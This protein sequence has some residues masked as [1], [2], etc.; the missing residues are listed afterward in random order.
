MLENATVRV[1]NCAC[2]QPF[3]V[4]YAISITEKN[5]NHYIQ[6][7]KERLNNYVQTYCSNCKTNAIAKMASK[8]ANPNN[9]NNDGKVP[10][11]L[12]KYP[13]IP[14]NDPQSSDSPHILCKNCTFQIRANI[15]NDT[16][17]G[18]MDSNSKIVTMK[19][20]V[21]M[22]KHQVEIKLLKPILK[23]EDGGCCE[24]L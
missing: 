11:S 6:Q 10:F 23:S 12:N 2:G 3:D 21:C 9:V 1:P 17:Q 20:E 7:A 8:K 15:I 22:K 13:I 5:L 19:C 16:K 14:E 18:K 24:I 4:E